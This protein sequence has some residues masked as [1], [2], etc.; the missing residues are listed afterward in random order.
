MIKNRF[1]STFNVTADTKVNDISAN[2][3]KGSRSGDEHEHDLEGVKVNV[4]WSC[5][6]IPINLDSLH[7]FGYV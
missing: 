1:H 4:L 6:R 5:T 3:R 7:S 2:F